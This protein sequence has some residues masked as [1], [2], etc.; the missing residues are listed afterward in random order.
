MSLK[1]KRGERDIVQVLVLK[2]GVEPGDE[3]CAVPGSGTAMQIRLTFGWRKKGLQLNVESC[4]ISCQSMLQ[5]VEEKFWCIFLGDW[6]GERKGEFYC[7]PH[8]A[9]QLPV[10]KELDP[11]GFQVMIDVTGQWRMRKTIQK[12]KKPEAVFLSGKPG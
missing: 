8:K 11:Y 2:S 10:E 3:P 12:F 1:G 7:C 5:G 4:F 9:W 6:R